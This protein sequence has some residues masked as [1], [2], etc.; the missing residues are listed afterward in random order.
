MTYAE[1]EICQL[2]DQLLWSFSMTTL[3]PRCK[4]QKQGKAS[5]DNRN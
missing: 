1:T 4:Q 3:L 5:Y 2:G